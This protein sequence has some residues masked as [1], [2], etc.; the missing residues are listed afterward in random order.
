MGVIF[1]QRSCDWKDCLYVYMCECERSR[2]RNFYP[3]IV[4][5]HNKFED[6]L[7]LRF[8]GLRS[9]FLGVT[10][11]DKVLALNEPVFY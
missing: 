4:K 6:G 10:S 5:I 8:S 3:I 1:V 2:G 7:G 9:P 11:K